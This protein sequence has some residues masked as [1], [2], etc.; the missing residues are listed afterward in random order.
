MGVHLY[1]SIRQA[2][3]PTRLRGLRSCH[4][5]VFHV[6]GEIAE[7]ALRVHTYL[8]DASLA[9]LV[10]STS[11]LTFIGAS[12]MYGGERERSKEEAYVIPPFAIS[13]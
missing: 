6:V 11:S 9:C 2:I 7:I 4:D 5:V 1:S 13:L 10:I 8:F 12:R 3:E